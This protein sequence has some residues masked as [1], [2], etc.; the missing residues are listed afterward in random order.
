MS[1]V[2]NK[3]VYH[4]TISLIDEIDVAKGKPYK[5]F[6]RGFYVT[7]NFSHAQNLAV[8]N[9]TLEQERSGSKCSAYVYTY[10]LDMKK[11]HN[12]KI[13]EFTIADLDWMRFVLSNRNTRDK[14]HDFD[15]IIG[16]TANDDT[17]IVLKSYFS[18][19][20]GDINSERALKL[21]LDMIEADNLPS[22]IYFGSNEATVCLTQKGTAR[23]V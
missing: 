12:F 2:D 20:Y 13:K 17:S 15:I 18:G 1:H 5:D 4:G 14:A 23:N 16:P 21:A 22:Q 11:A 9:K 3:V 10:T 7:E 6:G 8:R 19:L